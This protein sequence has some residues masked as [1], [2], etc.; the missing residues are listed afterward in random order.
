MQVAGRQVARPD[1]RRHCGWV[2]PSRPPLRRST[3]SSSER[4]P[5]GSRSYG[6]LWNE[7]RFAGP[8]RYANRDAIA[9]RDRQERGQQQRLRR[10]QSRA[11]SRRRDRRERNN[12]SDTSGGN[13]DPASPTTRRLLANR[14]DVSQA[15]LAIATLEA[16]SRPQEARSCLKS[17]PVA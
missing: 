12:R 1:G 9:S 15:G 11:G 6:G 13:L 17:A 2:G 4:L 7:S 16:S 5:T 14:D 8:D 3:P 10:S